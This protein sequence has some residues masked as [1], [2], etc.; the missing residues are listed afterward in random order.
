MLRL[1]AAISSASKEP[2]FD[3]VRYLDRLY[4]FQVGFSGDDLQNSCSSF[5]GGWFVSFFLDP[6]CVFSNQTRSRG[7]VI[8][9]GGGIR[10]HVALSRALRGT[11]LI[12]TS[13]FVGHVD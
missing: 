4:V 3:G 5:D 6:E 7:F 2:I 13:I 1:H 12:Q 9:A 8:G 10:T 11:F